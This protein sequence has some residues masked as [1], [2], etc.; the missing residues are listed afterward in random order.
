MKTINEEEIDFDIYT[1]NI[2]EDYLDEDEISA[3]EEGFMIGYL[4]E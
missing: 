3:A 1:E 4:A 2:V